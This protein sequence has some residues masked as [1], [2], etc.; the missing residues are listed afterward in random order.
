MKFLEILLGITVMLVA[1]F[2]AGGP[3]L[4]SEQH[5]ER[6]FV[7]KAA[8]SRVF[9]RINDFREFNK[10]SPWVTCDPE[11]TRYEFNGPASGI[12]SV[13]IIHAGWPA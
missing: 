1:L 11:E 6:S 4:P 12:G 13:P 9:S 2:V 3:V 8:P 5:V 10:G 7:V